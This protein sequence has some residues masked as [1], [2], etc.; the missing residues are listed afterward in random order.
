VCNNSEKRILRIFCFFI[1]YIALTSHSE[2]LN[3][4]CIILVPLPLLHNEE[5]FVI[6][7]QFSDCLKVYVSVVLKV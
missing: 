4:Q 3:I 2:L 1:R 6:P 5:K 7:I